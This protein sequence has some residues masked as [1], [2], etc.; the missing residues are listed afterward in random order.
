MIKN[1]LDYDMFLKLVDSLHDEINIWDSNY[2]LLYINSACERHYGFKKEDMIGKNY[3]DFMEEDYWHPALLPYVYKEKV[4]V[5]RTQKTHIG[6]TITSIVVPFFDENG[7]LE[8]V[9]SSIRD[10]LEDIYYLSVDE[11]ERKRYE[12][13]H[14]SSS[15]LLFKSSMMKEIMELAHTLSDVDS[16]VVILGESGVGKT[17]L[18]RVM[19]NS[20]KRKDKP[21]ITVNCG[22]I[23]KELMESELFG[24]EEGSFTGAK[25]QGKKGIF[26]AADGGTLLL[27]EISELPYLLQSKLLHVVQEKEFMP[28]GSNKMKKVDVKII[29]ATNKNLKK[30]AVAGSFREDLYYRLSVFEINI[31]PLRERKEDIELLTFYFLKQFNKTYKKNHQLSTEVLNI[32]RNYSWRGNIRELSHLIERLVVTV[33][34]FIIR[35]HHLPSSLF[36][37]N[38]DTVVSSQDCFDDMVDEFKKAI[39]VEA[40]NKYKSSRKVAKKLKISQSKATRLIRKYLDEEMDL[41][42]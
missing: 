34:D 6:A 31:P 11:I 21:F 32:L 23:P 42:D 37:I 41:N 15:S 4:P 20:S 25:K 7:E 30:L 16:P 24:Y 9:V 26:D 38:K 22:A 35:P 33:S 2:N 27:D 28:V 1:R 36:E 12:E 14:I 18:A 3:F 40:Y 19:H 10:G 29:T 39:V 8:Y 5:M 13:R 17:R